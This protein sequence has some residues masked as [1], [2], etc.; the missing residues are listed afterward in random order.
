MYSSY[1]RPILEYAAPAWR[2]HQVKH[3]TK[4]QKVQRYATRLIPELRG[5]SYEE[6]LLELNLTKL[7]DRRVRE[8]MNTTYKILRGE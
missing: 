6:K 2:L 7:E 8:D 1:V 4:L 5:M 3:K